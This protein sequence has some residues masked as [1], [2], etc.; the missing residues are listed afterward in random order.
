MQTRMLLAP[1]ML[2]YQIHAVLCCPFCIVIAVKGNR[3][4]NRSLSIVLPSTRKKARANRSSGSSKYAE[5]LLS[6]S[7]MR[8]SIP[9]AQHYVYTPFVKEGIEETYELALV[10][11]NRT[12]PDGPCLF[13]KKLAI[14]THSSVEERL[15]ELSTHRGSSPA[16][17][18]AFILHSRF[19]LSRHLNSTT[20]HPLPLT[21][22]SHL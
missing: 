7:S 15:S 8:H 1:P 6:S 16:K 9:R 5:E 13:Q 21:R 12:L 2:P 3:A 4:E 20:P 14:E 11:Q 18:R 19:V 17:P 22:N 10:R